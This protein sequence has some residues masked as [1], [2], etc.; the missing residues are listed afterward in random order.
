[1]K[2]QIIA[3][4]I[5]IF[6]M[7][8]VFWQKKKQEI[9]TQE[10]LFWQFFWIA[11]AVAIISLRSIDR[12]VAGL[13]FSASGID[14]LLYLAVAALFYFIIRLRLRLARMEKDITKIVR[15]ISLK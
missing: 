6:F 14:V 7:F 12:F 8:R 2:Q 10:F 3:L 13:G 15:D 5:I 11:A 1:M 9:N 4:L